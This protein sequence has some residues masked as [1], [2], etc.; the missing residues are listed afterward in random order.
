VA[1]PPEQ[2]DDGSSRG[3][4]TADGSRGERTAGSSRGERTAGSSR[5]ERTADGSRGE[6]TAGSSRGARTLVRARV[7]AWWASRA[8]GRVYLPGLVL[9]AVGLLGF[10][11]LLDSV[12]ERDDL[13]VFDE[14]VLTWLVANRSPTLTTVLSAVTLV[15]GP[16]VLPVLVGVGCLA[17]VAVRR[18]WRRPALLAGAM[19]ASSLVSLAVKSSVARPRP[20]AVDMVIPGAETTFSF[21]SGHTIGTATLALT[22]GYLLLARR[23]TRRAV[24]GWSIVALVSVGAV[25]LS[26][27]Y[28]GYHFVTDVAAALAL[29]VATLGAVVLVDRGCPQP[30]SNRQPTD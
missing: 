28:L 18:S 22:L 7:S 23:P 1:K 27:L 17:W 11:A 12:H 21:P 10:L 9:L 26:R 16:L 14:P 8:R 3:E 2:A 6:R 29:A 30:D 4:P 19:V 20:P 25:G 15:S 24:V 13:T 5:G